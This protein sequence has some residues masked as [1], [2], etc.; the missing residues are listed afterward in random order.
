[1]TAH[2]GRVH[3]DLEIGDRNGIGFYSMRSYYFQN[4]HFHRRWT[5]V[6]F[7][8]RRIYRQ[9]HCYRDTYYFVPGIYCHNHCRN[10][11]HVK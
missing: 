4:Y 9:M 6:Y 11:V 10:V 7:L 1:M 2:Y 3:N 8:H 5:G